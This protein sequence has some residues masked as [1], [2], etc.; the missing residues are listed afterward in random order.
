MHKRRRSA[1]M[2]ASTI[3]MLVSP[4]NTLKEGAR[5]VF[6]LDSWRSIGGLNNFQ[7]LKVTASTTT[8]STTRRSGDLMGNQMAPGDQM[9]DQIF[10]MTKM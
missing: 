5:H 2:A 6:S 9:G 8:R 1:E 7:L 10:N 4:D 3:A